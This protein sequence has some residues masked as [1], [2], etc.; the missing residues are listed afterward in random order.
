MTVYVLQGDTVYWN[1]EVQG[2]YATKEGAEKERDVLV[3]S[4]PED[5]MEE[6]ADYGLQYGGLVIEAHTVI[7][8]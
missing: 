6:Y 8:E 7:N 5:V 2:V 3:K 4:V 1:Y